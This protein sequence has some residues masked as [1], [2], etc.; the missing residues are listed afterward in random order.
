MPID[1]GNGAEMCVDDSMERARRRSREKVPDEQFL[2]RSG[3]DQV[4][5]VWMR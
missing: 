1:V 4:G 2:R 5:S 3:E